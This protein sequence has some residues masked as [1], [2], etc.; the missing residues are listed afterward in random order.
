MSSMS[1]NGSRFPL[2]FFSRLRFPQLFGL[3][4]ALLLLDL[5]VPDP[6]PWLDE[7]FLF[8]VTLMVGALRKPDVPGAPDLSKPPEKN[9]T[10]PAPPPAAS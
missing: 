9:V 6:I 5:L 7:A 1:T 4:G 2:T 8:V 3:L 10:P